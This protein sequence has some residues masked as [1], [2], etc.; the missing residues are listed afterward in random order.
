ML[1]AAT[2]DALQRILRQ[3][4]TLQEVL[5]RLDTLQHILIQLDAFRNA[6][7]SYCRCFPTYTLQE[8]FRQL[9]VKRLVISY[10]YIPKKTSLKICIA[11]E[12]FHN[13]HC[14]HLQRNCSYKWWLSNATLEFS[15]RHNLDSY[16]LFRIDLNG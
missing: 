14:W 3:L 11:L 1:L 13:F 5:W 9:K 4:C 16:L 8:S 15:I 7:G 2:V 10:I 6:T 12:F